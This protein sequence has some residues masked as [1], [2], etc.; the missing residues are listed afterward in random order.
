MPTSNQKKT[1]KNPKKTPAKKTASKKPEDSSPQERHPSGETY[2]YAP[3]GD[4]EA[5]LRLNGFISVTR[6]DEEIAHIPVD[7][8][9][10]GLFARNS[11]PEADI[12]FSAVVEAAV[13]VPLNRM[14]RQVCEEL[15]AKHEADRYADEVGEDSSGGQSAL[16]DFSPEPPEDPNDPALEEEGDATDEGEEED[17]SGEQ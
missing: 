5:D 3:R 10:A 12:R 14:V 17:T 4:T 16:P 6:A 1:A 11:L 2:G 13:T 8:F 9:I 7:M 15:L